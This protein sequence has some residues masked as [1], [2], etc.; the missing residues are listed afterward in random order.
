[1]L[2]VLTAPVRVLAH[3]GHGDEFQGG[4]Q[5]T[6]AAGAVKVDAQTQERTGIKVETA[7][8]Q[9]LGFGVKA[10]G[11]IE[12]LPSKRVEVTNP[13]G[14][15]VIKLFVQP[16]DSV[17]AGQP[18]AL[19]SSPDLVNLRAESLSKRAEAEGDTQQAKADLQLAQDNYSKQQQIAQADIQQAKVALNFAQERYDRDK[20]LSA[21]GALPRRTVLESEAKLAEAKAAFAKA[22][23][24]LPVAEATA[25]LK[26]A[27]SGVE[28][29]R[30]RVELSDAGYSA[31][32]QQLGATANPDGTVT[33]VAP[34]SGKVAD[35]EVTL[36]QS[37]KEAGSK[38]M[39]IIDGQA[40]LAT[41][42]IYE[43]DLNQIARGQ[44]VRVT[45]ASLPNRTF[46]G[47]IAVIGSVVEGSTRSVPVKAE[48][49]NSSGVL[50]PGMFTEMDVITERTP[51]SVLA[52]PTSA[53]VETNDK[54]KV[55]F[56]QNG[57]S[58]Q[59]S[60]VTLG[61]TAG[62]LVEIT[63]G[64]FDGDKI[65][66][67]GATQLYTQSLRGGTTAQAK[68]S[69]AA[70]TAKPQASGELPWWV[71][72]PIAGV[73]IAGAFYGGMVWTRKRDRKHSQY[74]SESETVYLAE[75]SSSGHK[76]RSVRSEQ[77]KNKSDSLN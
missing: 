39:T 24:Q 65:V 37:S 12:A 13:T 45:I 75:H 38:L 35:R 64:L 33:I 67:Q 56:V 17:Q 18:V 76:D 74:A 14:G 28:V 11:Q 77:S 26:R 1:M 59:P 9:R 27:Q 57:D 72:I 62:D 31:R 10:T 4:G 15:Q 71:M 2:L 60:E 40:V 55:V 51:A 63:N 41:A 20:E 49:D 7:T 34:I 50:K 21:T 25:Q 46:T 68:D 44:K 16:G 3:G 23:S 54:K 42:N 5:A 61:R 43:K 70:S 58:F 53:I 32:L 48:L 69:P 22:Q 73:A 19:L 36:G 30:S 8:R 29:A 52:V 66:T 6:Q 47:R